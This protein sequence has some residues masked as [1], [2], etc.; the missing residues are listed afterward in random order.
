MPIVPGISVI[1]PCHNAERYIGSALR[2]ILQQ[3]WP[4]LEIIVVDDG[5]T[6][7]SGDIVS[8]FSQVLLLRQANAGV[9]AARNRGIDHA[10][11]E[12]IAFLDADDLWLPGKLAA[13]WRMLQT[14]ADARMSYTA[15]ST[16][17]STDLVPSADELDRLSA[18]SDQQWKG[19]TGWIYP[20][21]LRDCVVWT[22]ST[23][24][25]RSVLDE[26]GRF[27]SSLHI[28]EDYDLWLRASRVTP[29]LRVPRPLALYRLHPVSLTR[30]APRENY[31][32]RVITSALRRWGYASPDG[33][34]A[35][36]I[37]VWRGLSRSWCDF[38]DA[39]WMAGRTDR[40]LRAAVKGILLDPSQSLGWL[41]LSRL[42]LRSRWTGA[43]SE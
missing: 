11:H 1:V 40:A 25:H 29:I 12:W 36:R 13:Q 20:Q 5:S 2:S 34:R 35:R 24:M 26:V 28:G 32:G 17:A 4:K 15:W 43:E 42:M 27:D 10:T 39:Q 31:R 22:S 30:S 18:S 6:D 33:T 8:T 14:Q 21:L 3:D 38:A 19:P 41:V 37:D 16:W 9:A 7:S 23:L